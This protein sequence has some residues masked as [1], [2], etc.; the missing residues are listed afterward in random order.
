MLKQALTGDYDQAM[1]SCTTLQAVADDQSSTATETGLLTA[2]NYLQLPANGGS[3]RANAQKV[4][5]L[6]TD[7]MANLKTSSNTTVSNYRTAH[8]SS[9]FYGGSSYVAD[10]ALMQSMSMQSQNWRVF[11]VGLGLG[12]DYD[13]MDRLAR[14]GNT[15]DPD[16]T[17]PRTSGNPVNYE[18]EL[19]AIFEEII[20]N[21]QVRLVQ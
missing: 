17:S 19:S 1:Q 21:P 4:V 14:L 18:A 15:A 6:L 5:V 13:F 11:S 3:G 8:S 7:G 12:C 16:G 2:K 20:N 10:A 9:D